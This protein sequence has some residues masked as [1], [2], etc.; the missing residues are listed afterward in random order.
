MIPGGRWLLGK[1][2][3]VRHPSLEREV[4]GRR[5]ANPVGM[6]AGFDPNGEVCRELG[7]RDSDSSRWAPSRPIRRGAIRVPASSG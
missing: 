7:L 1:C 2:F 4:F 3:A 5:F 6:A